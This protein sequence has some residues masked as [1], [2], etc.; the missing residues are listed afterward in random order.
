MNGECTMYDLDM[1][2]DVQVEY[3]YDNLTSLLN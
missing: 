3:H 2:L 1:T